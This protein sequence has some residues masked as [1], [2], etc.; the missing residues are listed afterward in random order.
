MRPTTKATAFLVLLL[1]PLLLSGAVVLPVPDGTPDATLLSPTRLSAP[2]YKTHGPIWILN[3]TAAHDMATAESW[4][5]NGSPETP[6]VIEGYNI[7]AVD[8]ACLVIQHVTL[9][10]EIRGCYLSNVVPRSYFGISVY[11]TPQISIVNTTIESVYVGVEAE[12]VDSLTVTNCTFTDIAQESIVTIQIDGA[13]IDHCTIHDTYGDGIN[14]HESNNT[15]ISDNQ[16]SYVSVGSGIYVYYSDFVTILNNELSY[17]QYSGIWGIESLNVTIEDNI[18]HDN[19]YYM[20]PMCGIHLQGSD[21]AAIVGNEI[22]H[23]ARN[24]IYLYYSDFAYVF[25]NLIYDN[26]DHGVDALYSTNGTITQN[27]IFDNG[28]WPVMINALCGIYL[29]ADSDGWVISTNQ[30]WNNTPSGISVELADNVEIRNN[31]IYNNT[32][33]GIYGYSYGVSEGLL[34]EENEVYGNGY[35]IPTGGIA[36]YGY[37]NCTI[38]GNVVY[39]NS[40]NGIVS[41]GSLNNI[42]YNEVYDTIGHGINIEMTNLNRVE[43]NVVHD[44]TEAGVFLYAGYTDVLENIVYD[45]AVGV[46]LYGS[47]LCS[48]YGNDIGWNGINALQELG[49]PNN[50]WYNGNS[51]YGNWWSDHVPPTGEGINIYPITNGTG[52]V[53]FDMYPECSLNLTSAPPISYEILETGNLLIWD[54]YA[55]NPASYI[56]FIDGEWAYSASWD[57]GPVE[58]NVDG[59][60][61]GFHEVSLAVMHISGHGLID[62][63]NVTVEDLTP[64][65]AISGYSSLQITVGGEISSQYSATDPSGVSWAVNDTVNFVID[66]SGL[67][68]NLNDLSVGEY[69]VR[70]TATDPYGHSVYLDVT[71]TVRPAGGGLPLALVLGVGGVG[72][73]AVVLIIGYRLKKG[74]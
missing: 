26:S 10:F 29:G 18:I 9:C 69:I 22:F 39:N 1:V 31:Q 36:L 25:D 70:I 53:A 15:L 28:W 13:T 67:L 66:S 4:D 24:G 48:I 2:S 41:H 43:N 50:E 54:A 71:I 51:T 73:V 34:I 30:I 16:I 65:S 62:D 60:A 74:S 7:T 12:I 32:D 55:K 56:V 35:G 20:G 58:L 40:G 21:Y 49:Q 68:T 45:N 8:K 27:D 14:L 59:F 52:M 5:G 17:C 57:G 37:E 61:N 38:T 63:S 47:M 72:A 64:P 42:T 3:D 19:W 23:N 33:R 11:D 44:N 6:Y 46:H